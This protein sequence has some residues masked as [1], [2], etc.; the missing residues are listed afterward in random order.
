M[1]NIFCFSNNLRFQK[2]FIFAKPG[3]PTSAVLHLECLFRIL[4]FLFYFFFSPKDYCPHE[5]P[6]IGT[7]GYACLSILGSL[8]VDVITEGM[9]LIIIE[10][11][12]I[13]IL[14]SMFTIVWFSLSNPSICQLLSLII[15]YML[16]VL[17]PDFLRNFYPFYHQIIDVPEIVFLM[18][19]PKIPKEAHCQSIIT[20]LSSG[21]S[22]LSLDKF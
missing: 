9:S 15:F 10:L 1:P 16:M 22:Y 3:S 2:C 20:V 18:F 21:S 11:P 13:F 14:T 17:S 12:P 19:N 4:V 6:L 5:L 7:P 8:I